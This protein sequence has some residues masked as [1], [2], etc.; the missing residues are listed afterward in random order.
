MFRRSTRS[1]E[2]TRS[3]TGTDYYYPHENYYQS[4][5][6]PVDALQANHQNEDC[7]PIPASQL[8]TDTSV[9]AC[10]SIVENGQSHDAALGQNTEIP[11]RKVEI[12]TKC[13]GLFKCIGEMELVYMPVN[14]PGWAIPEQLKC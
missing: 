8:V 7:I 13:I 11:P 3:S 10:T 5:D 12:R 6:V 1:R 9:H 14:R 4:Y 2:E